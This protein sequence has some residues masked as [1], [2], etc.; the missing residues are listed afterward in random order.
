MKNPLYVVTQKGTVVEE[1][2][3]FL[4]LILK[5]YGLESMVNE[6]FSVITLILQK[7]ASYPAL[8]FVKNLL[9]DVLKFVDEKLAVVEF[10][11]KSGTS[12]RA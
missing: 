8:E 5:K 2:T 3:N 4:D 6:L 11:L 7:F 1:A 12:T 10:F 9:D